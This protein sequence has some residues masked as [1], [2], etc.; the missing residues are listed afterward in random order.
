M[1]RKKS[2]FKKGDLL[3]DIEFPELFFAYEVVFIDNFNY[4]LLR[5]AHNNYDEKL[6]FSIIENREIVEKIFVKVTDL[7]QCEILYK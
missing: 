3:L 1:K 5:T 4:H 2:K 7:E 6:I